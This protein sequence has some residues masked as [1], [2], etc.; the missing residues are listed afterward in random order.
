[1]T[2]AESKWFSLEKDADG[3]EYIQPSNNEALVVALTTE[4]VVLFAREQS[5]A[6]GQPALILP[7]GAVEPDEPHAE[8]ANRELQ[9]EIGYKALQLDFLGEVWPWSKYLAVRT[10]LYLGRNLVLSKLDGDE[11]SA[12]E[13]VQVPLAACD[14]LIASGQLRDARAIAALSLVRT[15]LAH[16]RS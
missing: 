7:G 11:K 16:E 1:M 3:E 14:A 4:N 6:F 8:T 9:E 2:F 12:I 13:V 15:F 5:A 10:Y